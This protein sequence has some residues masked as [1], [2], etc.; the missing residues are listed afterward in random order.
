MNR[1]FYLILC[2]FSCIC[3]NT[4]V[5]FTESLSEIGVYKEDSTSF[6]ANKIEFSDRIYKVFVDTI[7]NNTIIQ[8]R[9]VGDSGEYY[10]SKGYLT[11]YSLG[12]RKFN[13]GAKIKF[14]PKNFT[15]ID[16]TILLKIGKINYCL[17]SKSGEVIW[18]KSNNVRFIDPSNTKALGYRFSSENDSG[19]LRCID[20]SSG[21]VLWERFVNRESGWEDARYLNDSTLLVSSSGLHYINLNSGS[22]WEYSANFNDKKITNVGASILTGVA[23][24][25]IS[26]GKFYYTS[27]YSSVLSGIKSNEIVADSSIYLA[28]DKLL[29][30]INFNSGKIIWSQEFL[31]KSVSASRL[32]NYDSSLCMV[33]LGCAKFRGKKIK[34]G[35]P[36]ISKYLKKTGDRLF[37]IEFDKKDGY[38]IG[39][40]RIGDVLY[41][42]FEEKISSYSMI[43]GS[44]I[45]EK[46]FKVRNNYIVDR[47]LF[48]KNK[49][50]FLISFKSVDSCL[51]SVLN[52]EGE[53][54]IVDDKMD[55]T[56]KING[57]NLYS[58]SFT[59][60]NVDFFRKDSK[61]VIANCNG[62][63]IANIELVLTSNK[64]SVFY[65]YKGT[66]FYE[67][68]LS[69]LFQ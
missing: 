64:G 3:Q 23:T 37:Y 56:L 34:Y 8:F 5:T 38:I 62:K 16:T 15:Q 21:N 18:K 69:K 32:Y 6:K 25:L 60:K 63:V 1:L 68:E 36:F 24:A 10:K 26:R 58:R 42:L 65:G 47:S 17:D 31:K 39:S 57:D 49:D 40:N 29:S 66:S 61:T 41:V 4:K 48:F 43:D 30:K 52:E 35:K 27:I 9:D 67:I 44:L 22:G 12:K 7:N 46:E 50:G 19:W 51:F 55:V 45:S 59:R 28:S 54:V 33:N 14:S 53:I 2:S 11:S 20:V 13:W